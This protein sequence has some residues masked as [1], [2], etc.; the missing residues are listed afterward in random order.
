[1]G[2][3]LGFEF[4]GEAASPPARGG[5]EHAFGFTQQDIQEMASGLGPGESAACS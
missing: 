4:E 3:L 1:V 2:A 5:D